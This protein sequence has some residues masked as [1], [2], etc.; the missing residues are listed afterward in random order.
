MMPK[1]KHINI[2]EYPYLVTTVTLKR[3]PIFA[4]PDAANIV[5][6]AILFGKKQKWYYLL[7]FVIMPDHIHF[8]IIPKGKNISECVKSIKGY[9]ARRIN[10]VLGEKG[11]IWQSG[12]YDY[13]LESEEKVLSR[14][15]Y[16]E[17]NPVRKGMVAYPEDYKFNSVNYREETD[18]KEYFWFFRVFNG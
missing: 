6:E 5:L 12:F 2:E 4:S 1:L 14:M 8:I 15:R 7:S 18:L 3:K 9:S 10:S 17:D 13:I 16:I 11:S